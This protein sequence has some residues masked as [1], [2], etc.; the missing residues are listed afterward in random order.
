MNAEGQPNVGSEL[1]AELASADSVDLL[2]AFVIWSGVR[3]LR[4]ALARVRE[5]GGKIRVITTTYMG[6]T[7]KKAIDELVKLGAEVHVALDART[8]KLHAKA[9]LLERSFGF[10][11]RIRRVIKSLAH[12][13]VRRTRMERAAVVER[14]RSCH[15]PSPG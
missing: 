11:D 5:R 10:D 14:R 3:H 7:E 8:T 9:W 1:R 6:A 12:G 2:C 4:E 15:R 13:A